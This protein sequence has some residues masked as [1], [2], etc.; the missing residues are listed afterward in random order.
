MI[1]TCL[2]RRFRREIFHDVADPEFAAAD[3]RFDPAAQTKRFATGPEL[4]DL[5]LAKQH[6][7]VTIPVLAI[8]GD[9]GGRERKPSVHGVRLQRLPDMIEPASD[10]EAGIGPTIAAAA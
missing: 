5:T 8:G 1:E 6:R 4:H 9:A 2:R 10:E 3:R 7:L